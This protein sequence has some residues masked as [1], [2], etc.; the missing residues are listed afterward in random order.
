MWY[1]CAGPDGE[2]CDINN[3]EEELR[4]DGS[5]GRNN[6]LENILG[7]IDAVQW[8]EGELGFEREWA[9]RLN[10]ARSAGGTPLQPGAFRDKG[11]QLGTMTPTGLW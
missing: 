4:D 3:I 8:G 10:G 2:T 11:S 6:L 9:V 7:R 1:S 5:A